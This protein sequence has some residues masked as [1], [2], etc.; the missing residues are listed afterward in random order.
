MPGREQHSLPVV[1]IYKD[2][3]GCAL[4]GKVNHGNQSVPTIIWP[5]YSF[6]VEP[7]IKQL[8]DKLGL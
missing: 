7:S 1:K 6:L 5:D 8:I 4:M 3:S 2:P